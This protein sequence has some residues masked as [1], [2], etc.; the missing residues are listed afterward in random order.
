MKLSVG[1]YG[2]PEHAQQVLS[3]AGNDIYEIFVGAP[4][5]ISG[6]GRNRTFNSTKESLKKMRDLTGKYGIRLT[7]LLNGS[8]FGG[9][10]DTP[11][12]KRKI[13]SFIGYLEEIGA[14]MVTVTNSLLMQHILNIRKNIE[15]SVST[16]NHV[17]NPIIAKVYEDM[18][19][20]RIKIVQTV[21]RDF[22]TL[23]RIRSYVSS[24]LELYAN[25]KCLYGSNCPHFMSHRHYTAHKAG[26]G[27]Y[28]DPYIEYC[29]VQ[30]KDNILHTIMAPLIRPEDVHIYEGMGFDIFKLAIRQFGPEQAVKVIK[31]YS[32]RRWDGPIGEL[33]S[34][35]PD[36]ETPDNRHFD[37]LTKKLTD[38]APEEQIR[39]Y[40]ELYNR[41]SGRNVKIDNELKIEDE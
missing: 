32:K 28:V 5:D 39:T 36:K 15:V 19:I 38:V 24:E 31:A 16:F 23:K 27:D 14:D 3:Q 30:R 35:F 26:T 8:C 11:E 37:G 7:V 18:G 12:F 20:E 2:E 9:I 40:K 41:I 6:S 1:F 4:P 22:Q 21:N 17:D 10:E 29:K 13:G 25:S 33:W 34:G